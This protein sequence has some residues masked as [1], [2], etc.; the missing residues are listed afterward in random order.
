MYTSEH[1]PVQ[2]V[3]HQHS[4]GQTIVRSLPH[5]DTPKRAGAIKTLQRL[6]LGERPSLTDTGTAS[7]PRSKWQVRDNSML[8]PTGQLYLQLHCKSYYFV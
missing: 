1:D 5:Q 2:M 4:Q 7:C 8:S 6:L 3:P